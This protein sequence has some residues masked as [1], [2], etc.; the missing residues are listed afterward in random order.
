MSYMRMLCKYLHIEVYVTPSY[1]TIIIIS[2][3][4]VNSLDGGRGGKSGTL[5]VQSE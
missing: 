2:H 3:V 4:S 5:P 1:G